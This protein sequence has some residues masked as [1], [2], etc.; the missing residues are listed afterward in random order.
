M[1][2]MPFISYLQFKNIV[3]E[4]RINLFER[5]E[6]FDNQSIDEYILLYKIYREF[7][8]TETTNS[9]SDIE[10][11][12]TDII[13]EENVGNIQSQEFLTT[14]TI[15]N[16]QYE[17]TNS[18]ADIKIENIDIIFEENIEKLELKK[19]EQERKESRKTERLL[20]HDE[21]Q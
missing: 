7:R 3:G 2:E 17:T 1:Q 11:E 20:K 6:K 9:T 4:E 8:K 15:D 16:K 14:D 19:Q 10:I 13:F 18:T 21:K 12:N 5:I